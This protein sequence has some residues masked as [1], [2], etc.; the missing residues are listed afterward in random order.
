VEEHCLK[1]YNAGQQRSTVE[2][3]R[4]RVRTMV[5]IVTTVA[6][7]SGCAANTASTPAA[8]KNTQ[9]EC[10]RGGGWWRVNLDLCEAQGTGKQ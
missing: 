3:V 6:L 4:M 10:E 7:L 8:A 9:A 1:V 5:G 2:G